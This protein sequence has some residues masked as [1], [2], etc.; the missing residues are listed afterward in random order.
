VS[1]GKDGDFSQAT[2]IGQV[3]ADLATHWVGRVVHA[4][5][6][7]G[8]H[9]KDVLGGLLGLNTEDLEWLHWDGV[10]RSSR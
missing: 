8:S 6:D 4:S 9:N 7:A 5:P 3:N 1:F 2:F 10:T